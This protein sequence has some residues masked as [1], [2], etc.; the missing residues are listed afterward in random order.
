LS[1]PEIRSAAKTL[2]MRCAGRTDATNLQYIEA[3]EDGK[4]R[5]S[6][7]LNIYAAMLRLADA[8]D[9]VRAAGRAFAIDT[10]T[11]D[12]GSVSRTRL[13]RNRP[14]WL[15]IHHAVLRTLTKIAA[16]APHFSH[17]VSGV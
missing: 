15:R 12:I 3:R 17:G 13:G 1:L 4:S 16:Q 9:I 2:L 11:L 7:D 8:G 5:V 14:R 6:F 10:P